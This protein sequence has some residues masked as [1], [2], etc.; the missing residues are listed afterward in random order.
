MTKLSNLLSNMDTSTEN[1]YSQCHKVDILTE[2]GTNTSRNVLIT[3]SKKHNYLVIV[4]SK[5]KNV[6]LQQKYDYRR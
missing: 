6:Y 1:L 3:L 4:K 2:S 5:S